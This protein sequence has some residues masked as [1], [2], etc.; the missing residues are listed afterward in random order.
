MPDSQLQRQGASLEVSETA[1]VQDQLLRSAD[2]EQQLATAKKNSNEEKAAQIRAHLCE[3]LSD[4]ILSDPA[5]ALKHD[6]FGKLWR[7]CFYA[8]IGVWRKKLSREKKKLGPATKALEQNFHK[9][10]REA[11]LMYEYLVI[12]YQ[13]KLVPGSSEENSQDVSQ[14]STLDGSHLGSTEGVVPGLCTFFG[15]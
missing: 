4:L 10:L 2:L 11:M 1:R 3:V 6:V 12:Q 5:L 9:F 14:G 8:P 7:S 13:S 15:H